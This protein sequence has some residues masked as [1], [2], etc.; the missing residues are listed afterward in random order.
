MRQCVLVL[1]LFALPLSAATDWP[2]DLASLVSQVEKTHPRFR[3][4]KAAAEFE[5]RA[6]ELASRAPG[7]SDAQMIVE[8]Q[9]LLASIGDGHT[10]AFPFAL[11]KIP[12]M[13]WWF[14]DGVYVVDAKE[15]S[16]IGRRVKTIGGLPVDD[17]FARLEPYIS[18]DNAMQ[19]RWATPFYA[20]L[21]DF[22]AAI[23]ATTALT[24]D[25]GETATLPAEAIDPDALEL[26][27][28][29]R[30]STR[31][32]EPFRT[33]EVNGRILLITVNGMRDGSKTTLAQF[34][35]DL[36]KKIAHYDRAIVDLRLNNGG[37]ASKADEL[38]R[39]LI[40]FDARGGKLVTLISR[41]TF[42][43]AQT[44]ATRLD[45]WTNTRFAGE[46]TG[47]R[48]NHYGNERPFKLPESKLR[49]T[50]SSGFNQPVTINDDRDAI[51]PDIAIPALASDYFAGRDPV[52]DAAKKSLR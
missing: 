5:T 51:R 23:G 10:L 35:I 8:T 33:E 1:F 2:A 25:T 22:L 11:K 9:R 20:T 6:N 40:A 39:T 18:H 29:P 4:C 52:L 14:D 50:I 48:P 21:P 7:L 32:D 24:F 45:Q 13:L 47:S 49:G 41:M 44:F 43:A 26:K 38:L 42:S 19:L 3:D 34:G 46:P 37:E 12:V 17:V 36:R 31:T 16:L 28:L 27:L 15:K 30:S